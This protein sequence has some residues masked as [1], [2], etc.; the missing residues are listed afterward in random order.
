MN[1]E[2]T[3]SEVLDQC[4]RSAV[5]GAIRTGDGAPTGI[6][7]NDGIDIIRQSG[8][9]RVNRSSDAGSYSYDDIDPAEICGITGSRI[10]QN[11]I[12][13]D[14]KGRGFYPSTVINNFLASCFPASL[15]PWFVASD[16]GYAAS[17][18]EGA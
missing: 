17:V 10:Y 4:C 13:V 8:S 2:F 18:A 15:L 16:P 14:L 5:P 11:S 9:R 3:T 6:F 1:L 7:C 12:I